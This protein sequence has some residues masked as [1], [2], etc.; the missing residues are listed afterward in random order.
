MATAVKERKKQTSNEHP[1]ITSSWVLLQDSQ[2][3]GEAGS[4]ISS[5]MEAEGPSGNRT[6]N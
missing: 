3:R 2:V 1:L 5:L 4:I 6:G